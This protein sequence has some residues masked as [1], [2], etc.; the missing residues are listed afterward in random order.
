M[1]PPKRPD[2]INRAEDDKHNQNTSVANFDYIAQ[3]K[4]V[5][6]SRFLFMEEG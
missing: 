3:G 6:D 5:G 4:E 1:L 2:R